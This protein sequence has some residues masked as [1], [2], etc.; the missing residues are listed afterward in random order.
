MK[1]KTLKTVRSKSVLRANVRLIQ[2]DWGYVFEKTTLV[3]ESEVL[4]FIES[5][6]R[7]RRMFKGK[8]L[9]VQGISLISETLNSFFEAIQ[10]MNQF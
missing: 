1:L 5:G 2:F 3:D 4:D 6:F 7:P 9:M 10:R 8:V